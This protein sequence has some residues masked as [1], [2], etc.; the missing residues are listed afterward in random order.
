M[1]RDGT[2][3]APRARISDDRRIF[4]PTRS[5][6]KKGRRDSAIR[7]PLPSGSGTPHNYKKISS[8]PH[9]TLPLCHGS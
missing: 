5:P 3:T 8:L 4:S 7:V 1:G 2:D 9:E 6:K